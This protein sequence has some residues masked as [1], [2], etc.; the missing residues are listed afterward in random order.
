MF[1]LRYS[2]TSPFVRKVRVVALE[3][4]QDK[5]IE[6]IKTVTADPTCDIG[7]DNPLNK[8]PALVLED[9]SSLYDSHVICEFLDARH[10]GARIF[11][12]TGPAR[13]TALRQEALANGMADAGV[14]RMMEN[15]R[16]A[17]EQSPAWIVRQKLKMDQGLDQ[18]EREAL[19]FAKGF[20][21]GLLTIAIVLDYFDFRFKAEDWR[22]GRPNLTKWHEAISERPSLKSTLPFE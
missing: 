16:P 19:A 1:K 2:S 8:V 11:P 22:K 13:W 21:I 17:N 15:R 3:T 5:D 18:L 6:L 20:D 9:G 14:L 4:G 10:S 7:K 12:A